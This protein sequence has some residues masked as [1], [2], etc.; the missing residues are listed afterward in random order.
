NEFKTKSYWDSSDGC[1]LFSLNGFLKSFKAPDA[2]QLT[3]VEKLKVKRRRLNES[4]DLLTPSVSASI[5][6]V[7]AS[8]APIHTI[9]TTGV[10][11]FGI[12]TNVSSQ[13]NSR[14]FSFSLQFEDKFKEYS[15]FNSKEEEI[16]SKKFVQM[17]EGVCNSE[18]KKFDANAAVMQP[19]QKQL[20][21]QKVQMKLKNSQKVHEQLVGAFSK[22]DTLEIYSETTTQKI[23]EEKKIKERNQELQDFQTVNLL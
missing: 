12:P 15:K 4:T 7:L 22:S 9:P 14:K 23:V 8:N 19:M 3:E 13:D 10:T 17:M 2:P 11:A 18:M 16:V 21:F 20:L 5:P 6:E 1:M